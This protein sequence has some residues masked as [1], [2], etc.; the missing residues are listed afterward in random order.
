MPDN[1]CSYGT[2]NSGSREPVVIE[3]NRVLDS[4]RDRDCFEDVRVQLTEYGNEI[5]DRTGSVRV[6]KACISWSDIHVDPIQFNRGFY[7]VDI[8]FFVKLEFEACTCPG[9]P[10]EFDG[11]A[12]LDKRVVLF[13]GESNTKMFKSTVD[14]SDYCRV[15]EI[16]DCVKN[17]PSVVVETVDPIVLGSKIVEST[18][19]RCCCCCCDIPDCVAS[20]LNG[21]LSDPTSNANGTRYLAVSLGLFSVVRMIRPSQYLINAVEYNVPDKEC[22][23]NCDDD[24]CKVFRSMAF[25]IGEFNSPSLSSVPPRQDKG[26]CGCN[27]DGR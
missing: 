2:Q 12:V 6:K 9:R 22:V 15:P 13:G 11:V 16:K 21:S 19:E 26:K 3:T 5:I 17:T 10:Q 18:P 4:C 14:S 23:S 24:P 1:R 8:R 20:T 25:P 7:S 27:G